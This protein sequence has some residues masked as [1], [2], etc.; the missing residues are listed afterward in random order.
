[1]RIV[2]APGEASPIIDRQSLMSLK[3]TIAERP[4]PREA[5]GRIVESYNRH[6]GNDAQALEN[7]RRLALPGSSCVVAGQQLG[8]MGGPAYTV[9]KGISCLLAAK[10][11]GAIPIF[12]LAT[13]DH[14]IGEIDHTYTIDEKGNLKRFRLAFPQNG[15]SVEDLI[16][17]ENHLEELRHFYEF[18]GLAELT[19]PAAGEL[20]STAMARVL[21]HL[22][23]GTG[24]VFLEPKCLRPLAV[25]FFLREVSECQAIYRLLYTTKEQLAQEGGQTP[26]QIAEGTNLFVRDVHG[27]RVKIRTDGASY[28]AGAERYTLQELLAKIADQPELF[29][30]NVIARPA[31]QNL[32]LPVIA[33]VVG[34]TEMAYH[35]QL[36][37]YFNYYQIP[38]PKL[39]PRLSAS[40]L[41]ADAAAI[42]EGCHLNP[43]EP[44][45]Q[46]WSEP[47]ASLGLPN[48][49]LH[50]LNNLLHPH[51]NPQDRVLNWWTF[52][53]KTQENMIHTALEHFSWNS[54]TSYYCYL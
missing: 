18:F 29:S 33:S 26:I 44:I 32:L 28:T 51:Q 54:P 4:Y 21:V 37:D 46:H 50:L 43:W 39:I 7:V 5:L 9:L 20:Y 52:Q 19:L 34:P 49:G 31:L 11:T 45:P 8:L 12:W 22:F 10:E 36:A 42:L 1:M 23:A 3:Q 2:K 47:L 35:N 53:S 24:L 27:K 40:F 15:S 38:A 6:I 14:D 41:P 16:L 48:H 17:T 13:E 25:P 30:P